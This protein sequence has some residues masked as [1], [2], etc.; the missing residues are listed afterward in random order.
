[1]NKGAAKR[2][3]Q[4][5][6]APAGDDLEME[7][8][9]ELIYEAIDDKKGEN[10]IVLDL[11]GQVDYLDYLVLCSGATEVHN[12]A[13]ADNVVAA[14]ERYD[15]IPDALNGYRY[16]NWVL[17]DYG[18]LVVHVFKPELREFYRLEDLWAGAR[19]VEMR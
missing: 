9:L 12:R 15:I 6:P 2:A 8:V 7:Q 19:A 5:R 18:V 16:G 3:G 4:V 1:M 10:I 13:I 17:I 11:A 14:L